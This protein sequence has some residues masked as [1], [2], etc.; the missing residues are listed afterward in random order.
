MTTCLNFQE[1]ARGKSSIVS[2]NGGRPYQHHGVLYDDII[3]NYPFK[4]WL[5]NQK[6]RYTNQ[7]TH[8]N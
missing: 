8:P 3:S 2:E 4:F 1:F 5:A 6:V 7:S